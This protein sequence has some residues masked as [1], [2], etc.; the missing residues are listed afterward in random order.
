[1]DSRFL[2]SKDA[3]LPNLGAGHRIGI[4]H[5]ANVARY[6]RER[7]MAELVN[8]RT[9]RK[10]AKRR[11]DDERAHANRLAHGRPAHLRKLQEATRVKADRDLDAHQIDKGGDP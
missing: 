2:R 3:S 11:Q 8:L 10:R 7:M 5:R 6:R 4:E 9:A 1:M